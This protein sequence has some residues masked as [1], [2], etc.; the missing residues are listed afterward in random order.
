MQIIHQGTQQI[1][2]EIHTQ[3]LEYT[4]IKLDI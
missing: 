3:K 4:R 2:P 1:F